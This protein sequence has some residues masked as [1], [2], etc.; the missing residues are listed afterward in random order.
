[1]KL[2]HLLKPGTSKR[3]LLFIA[4]FVWTFAGG[5]LL[6]RGVLMMCTQ[7]DFLLVRMAISIVGGALFYMLPWEFLCWVLRSG[8]IIPEF[9]SIN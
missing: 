3:N 5:M 2:I 1:M 4:A 7:R 8:F 9:L 6:I